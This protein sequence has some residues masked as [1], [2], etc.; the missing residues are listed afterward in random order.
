MFKNKF[1][2]TSVSLC[3]LLTAAF[4]WY[5]KHQAAQEEALKWMEDKGVQV[6]ATPNTL[7]KKLPDNLKFLENL[8]GRD[9]SSLDLS[10]KNRTIE[11][12]PIDFIEGPI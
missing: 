8:L 9:I 2:V 12:D 5:S 6:E 7:L 3:I 10:P 1:I 4:Y 11:Q